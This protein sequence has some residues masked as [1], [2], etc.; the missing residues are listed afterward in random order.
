MISTGSLRIFNVLIKMDLASSV[1]LLQRAKSGDTDAVNR[2]VDLYLL[3]LRRWASGRLPRWARDLSDTEDLVQDAVLGTLKHL[4]EFQP[5]RDGALHAYLRMAVMNAIRDEL[6]RAHRRPL[7]T[8]LDEGVPRRARL[9]STW[10]ARTR[11]SGGTKP[12]S[13][14]FEKRSARSSSRAWTLIS[15]MNRS[16]SR[17]AGRARMRRVWPCG[18][19]CSSYPKS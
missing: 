4:R 8:E 5:S 2:L 10:L 11:R 9:L 7:R 13:A 3:P 15:P 17:L 14:G 6:R 18:E 12:P 1:E 16:P 19:R